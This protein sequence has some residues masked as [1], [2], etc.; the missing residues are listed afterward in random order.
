MSSHFLNLPSRLLFC[1]PYLDW[2]QLGHSLIIQAKILEVGD[3]T[4]KIFPGC[5]MGDLRQTVL[6]LCQQLRDI[7]KQGSQFVPPRRPP[8]EDHLLL[9]TREDHT[10]QMGRKQGVFGVEPTGS[11]GFLSAFL[12]ADDGMEVSDLFLTQEP[13]EEGPM[14][15]FL[16]FDGESWPQ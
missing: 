6:S 14:F 1:L 13:F 3:E 2:L 4:W 5:I 10:R 8:D 9:E 16:L 12:P 11:D 15:D 7:V